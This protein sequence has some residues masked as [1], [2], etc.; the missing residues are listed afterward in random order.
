[1]LRRFAEEP[2]RSGAEER[3]QRGPAKDIHIRK[4]G[5]LSQQMSV[6]QAHGAGPRRSRAELVAEIRRDLA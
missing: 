3:K 4:Q 2:Y 1:M 5:G 6:D